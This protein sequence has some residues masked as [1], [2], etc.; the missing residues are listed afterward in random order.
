MFLSQGNGLN[1]CLKFSWLSCQ[2][3]ALPVLQK[4]FCYKQA[5]GIYLFSCEGDTEYY[6]MN[7]C[8]HQRNCFTSCNWKQLFFVD[9]QTSSD[10]VN[11]IVE[12]KRIKDKI[13]I[14]IQLTI[15]SLWEYYFPGD[16]EVYK[17]NKN[18]P[19]KEPWTFKYL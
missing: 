12:A 14:Y 19:K 2:C 1:Y 4:T 7:D 8:F 18:Y 3:F 16:N 17:W 11:K 15:D 10:C 6:Y 9:F 5:F 13:P